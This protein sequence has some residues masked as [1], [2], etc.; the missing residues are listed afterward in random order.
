MCEVG[1][2]LELLAGEPGAQVM[3]FELARHEWASLSKP[4]LGVNGASASLLDQ[5]IPVLDLHESDVQFRRAD[6]I[7]ALAAHRVPPALAREMLQWSG[8]EAAGLDDASVIGL[9]DALQVASR[10]TQAVREV[11]AW[12]GSVTWPAEAISGDGQLARRMLDLLGPEAVM[13]VL[14][15]L[16]GTSEVMG[17]V[18]WAAFRAEDAS[19]MTAMSAA[20]ITVFASARG[21]SCSTN[22]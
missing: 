12:L 1:T 9:V 2:G 13:Q 22:D 3:E 16:S 15:D 11:L 14:P 6:D 8:E 17:A 10:P 4:G 19:V 18:V 5:L 7:H 21:A 20:I